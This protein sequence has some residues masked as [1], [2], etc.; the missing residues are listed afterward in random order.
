MSY[1]RSMFEGFVNKE[2]VDKLSDEELECFLI[3]SRGTGVYNIRADKI[4]RLEET[5]DAFR[6]FTTGVAL[7]KNRVKEL[8]SINQNCDTIL[9]QKQIILELN[10]K[11]SVALSMYSQLLEKIGFKE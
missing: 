7:Y 6:G 1:I 11:L 2:W 8:E 5:M 9:A 3:W 10:S 4:E